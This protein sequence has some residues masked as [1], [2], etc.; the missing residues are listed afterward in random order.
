VETKADIGV[1][2]APEVMAGFV[3]VA[4]EEKALL[5]FP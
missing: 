3:T 2:R 1:R 4:I 5:S